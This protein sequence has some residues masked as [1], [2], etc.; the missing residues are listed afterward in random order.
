MPACSRD[1]FSRPPR[2]ETITATHS[3]MLNTTFPSLAFIFRSLRTNRTNNMTTVPETL[4]LDLGRRTGRI[5]MISLPIDGVVQE[6]GSGERLIDV[7]N[8]AGVQISPVC[9]R[10]QPRP[11]Q[12]CD[13]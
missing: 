2:R 5:S 9:D 11:I 1:N 4:A 6:A 13:T 10:P 3:L 12:T 8:R 7:I